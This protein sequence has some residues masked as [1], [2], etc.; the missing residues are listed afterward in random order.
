MTEKYKARVKKRADEAGKDYE[1]FLNE[2]TANVPLRKYAD[3]K[4]VA[5]AI[6][7][8]L[9]PFADHITGENI[10]CDGGFT[11]RY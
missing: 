3:P 8:L 9:S 4:E 7:T 1:S 2:D 11:R 10:M 5:I 6:E